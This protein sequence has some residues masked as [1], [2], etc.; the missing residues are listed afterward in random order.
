MQKGFTPI[1][2]VLLIVV[3]VGGAVYYLGMSRNSV[4]VT[5]PTPQTA[6]SQPTQVTESTSS[7]D[8]TNWKTY[9][10]TSVGYSIKHPP[11]LQI[12]EFKD[13]TNNMISTVTFLREGIKEEDQLQGFTVYYRIGIDWNE[14]DLADATINGYQAKKALYM[15]TPKGYTADYWIFSPIEPDQKVVRISFSTFHDE[16]PYKQEYFEIFLKILSTFK[17]I[18]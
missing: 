18:P 1:L 3:V 7:A 9:T 12:K 17:F 10:N 4:P 2:I 16:D 15:G 11:Q 8:I 6:N 5:Q 13:S 14:S